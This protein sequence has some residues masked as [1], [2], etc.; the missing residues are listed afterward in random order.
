MS[1]EG[2]DT[3]AIEESFI[4]NQIMKPDDYLFFQNAL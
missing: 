3:K 1:Q 4:R 2:Q